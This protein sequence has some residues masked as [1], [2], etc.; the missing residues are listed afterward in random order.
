MNFMSP[1][2]KAAQTRAARKQ[3]LEPQT[4]TGENT[5]QAR[6]PDH[7]LQLVLSETER[8][9]VI[10]FRFVKD[11][12]VLCRD[13]TQELERPLLDLCLRSRVIDGELTGHNQLLFSGPTANASALRGAL[14]FMVKLDKFVSLAH[15]ESEDPS[16]AQTVNVI[17][18]NLRASHI[19]HVQSDGSEVSFKRGAA[20]ISAHRIAEAFV[21]LRS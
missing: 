7:S 2:Q 13:D 1:A 17:A 11:G 20:Y 3:G 21:A 16:F 9:L 10:T 12:E 14:S 5:A 18:A 19:V 15:E 8:D 4:S 6:N